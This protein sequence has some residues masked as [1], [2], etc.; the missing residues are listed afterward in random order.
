MKNFRRL[1][2]A[3]VLTA[4]FTV[5]ALADGGETQ[6]PAATAPGEIL[7]PPGFTS[8]GD[9]QGPS[10]AS[11][12]EIGCPGVTALGDV[13]SPAFLGALLELSIF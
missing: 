6:G 7:T 13:L 8:Q 11:T 4:V 5:P 12:G 10:V 9:T 3:V 1:C 2:F